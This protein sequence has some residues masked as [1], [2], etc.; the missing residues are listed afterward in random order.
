MFQV[1]I[2]MAI[3]LHCSG[4]NALSQPSMDDLPQRESP[5]PFV[6][7][8]ARELGALG[9]PTGTDPWSV[10]QN[11]K[12]HTLDASFKTIGVRVW[13]ILSVPSSSDPYKITADLNR[14]T[15]RNALGLRAIDPLSGRILAIGTELVI[16]VDKASIEI[17]GQAI[18]LQ[19]VDVQVQ[20]S[21]SQQGLTPTSMIGEAGKSQNL[22]RGSFRIRN[23]LHQVIDRWTQVVT[24]SGLHWSVINDVDLEDYLLAVVPSEMPASF[25]AEA[26]KAQ[27]V[28]ARTYAVFHQWQ[29]R[30]IFGRVWDVDPTTWFQSY[31]GASVEH[32]NITPA[33]LGTRGLFLSSDDRVIEAFFSANSGGTTCRIK[34]GRASCR[35]RV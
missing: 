23:T 31:R 22:Y 13:P 4:A 3:L 9:I 1:P 18:K 35:E 7:S 19:D 34:I 5:P 8:Q 24:Y 2:W 16:R 14:V 21:A 12:V 28:A 17:G 25:G 32:P 6:W 33:V 15:L 26:L 30:N 11:F 10:G 20:S 27:A 29:A